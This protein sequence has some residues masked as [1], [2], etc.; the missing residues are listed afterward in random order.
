MEILHFK[1]LGDTECCLAANAVV[2]V[3]VEYQ[4][5]IAKYL[6][7]IYPH[8]KFERSVQYIYRVESSRSTKIK[9]PWASIG[10]LNFCFI[11]VMHNEFLKLSSSILSFRTFNSSI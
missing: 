1:Y 5:S 2:Q 11:E 3:I 8:I 6:R 10:P 4:I 9:G 7:G